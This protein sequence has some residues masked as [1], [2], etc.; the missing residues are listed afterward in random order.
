LEGT[1]IG[2]TPEK[3]AELRRLAEAATPGPWESVPDALP[4]IL[5]MVAPGSRQVRSS[6]PDLSSVF[7]HRVLVPYG[8]LHK[9]DGDFI[10]AANPAT[11]LSLLDALDAKDAKLAEL[12]ARLHQHEGKHA[13]S[14]LLR[15]P[16]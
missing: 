2:L 16:R 3:R 8:F 14:G 1:V 4:R 12:A 15:E 7:G 10:A 9:S 11:V 5:P 13:T 6:D